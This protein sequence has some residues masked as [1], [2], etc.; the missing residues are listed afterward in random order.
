MYLL[1]ISKALLFTNRTIMKYYNTQQPSYK[2]SFKQAVYDGVAPGNGLYLPHHRMLPD[3]L[4]YFMDRLSLPELA[5][6]VL[7]PH[8]AG[9]IDARALQAICADSFNFPLPLKQLTENGYSMELFHGPTASFKDFGAR[10]LARIIGYFNRGGN[11]S[12]WV[13]TATSGD[14]GSAVAQG[15]YK[16]PGVQ[17]VVLYPKNKISAIQEAQ[18]TSLGENIHALSVNGDFDDCQQLAKAALNSSCLKERVNVTSANSINIAR[19]LPQ[20]IYYFYGYAKLMSKQKPLV[21][22]VPGGNFGNLT[23]GILATK[24]GLMVARFV[25]AT[26]ANNA[27]PK[28]L[29]TGNYCPKPSMKTI[30]NAMDVGHPNNFERLK[31]LLGKHSQF[32]RKITGHY[33]PSDQAILNVV[34]TIHNRYG[35]VADPHG[36]IAYAGL[37][38]VLQPHQAGVFLATA[39]PAKFKEALAPVIPEEAMAMPTSLQTLAH[40]MPKGKEI[41]AVIADLE[42]YILQRY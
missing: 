30:A 26:N 40:T 15:F 32:C 36:A 37:E 12:N 21:Y 16:I 2:V 27:V 22:A 6:E 19:L 17:V 10:F 9:D 38:Q 20:M 25:A 7:Y 31:A 11:R 18:M 39:H 3:A 42:E 5:F 34:E 28:F 23:A 24:V 14:T 13:I 29:T 35:Y 8:V 33:Q 4:F 1:F 41:E